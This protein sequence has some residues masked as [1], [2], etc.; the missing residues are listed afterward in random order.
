MELP[1]HRTVAKPDVLA[2]VQHDLANGRTHLA[3]Q[4][5]RTVLASEPH[6]LELRRTLASIYRRTGNPAEAGR[7][8]YLTDEVRAEEVAAFERANPSP[9][10]QLRLL[11]FTA[12][13]AVLSPGARARLA[14]LT[15][16]AERTGPPSTWRGPSSVESPT[17]RPITV[18]CLFVAIAL[19]VFAV[20]TAIGIYRAVLWV[21]H[22]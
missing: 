8:D 19:T 10:L 2:R 21:T 16:R 11:R 1:D 14:A 4:R 13:P 9:W 7:W 6:D 20:L 17:R 5:L 12:D 15:E 3:I 22:F 18:P